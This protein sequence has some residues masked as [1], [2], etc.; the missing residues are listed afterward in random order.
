VYKVYVS[1]A[2]LV[3]LLTAL[4]FGVGGNIP[5]YADNVTSANVTLVSPDLETLAAA[6][7]N[8]N[9]QIADFNV[10]I[11][12]FI[13]WISF[14]FELFLMLGFIVISL[15][16]RDN[17]FLYAF[18]AVI[19]STVGAIWLSDYHIIGF[20]VIIFSVYLVYEAVMNAFFKKKKAKVGD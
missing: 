4:F 2:L 1:T 8:I 16:Q 20:C 18:T 12:T 14:F 3:L 6:G 10:L 7:E 11:G 15:W 19:T 17:V 9:T 5:C 13:H